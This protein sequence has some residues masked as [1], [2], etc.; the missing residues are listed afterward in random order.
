[1]FGTRVHSNDSF[2]SWLFQGALG[3]SH[4]VPR[5]YHVPT[6]AVQSMRLYSYSRKTVFTT[7]FDRICLLRHRCFR[8]VCRILFQCF[9]SYLKILF[10]ASLCCLMKFFTDI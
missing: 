5:H 6:I 8:D 7:S 1:M 9:H 4:H 10:P 3:V 2:S